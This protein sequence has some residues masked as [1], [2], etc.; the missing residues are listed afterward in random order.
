MYRDGNKHNV[1]NEDN[2]K[3]IVNLMLMTQMSQLY[4]ELSVALLIISGIRDILYNKV[5]T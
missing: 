1:V 3:D 4:Y 5:T 2:S